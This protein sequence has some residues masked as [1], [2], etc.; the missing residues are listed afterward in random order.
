LKRFT[1]SDGGA[2]AYSDIG[3]AGARPLVLLH[4]LMAHSGF[5]REQEPLSQAF[6]LICPDLRGH[7]RSERAEGSCTV[8]RAAADVAELAETLDLQNA[9]GIG[10]SLGAT[11]LWQ[12]LAGPA[13][14]RF[15]GAVVID[16]TARVRNGDGWELGLS[17]EACAARSTAMQEDFSAFA[18]GA[19]Q[20][21]FAQP[22]S[23]RHQPTAQWAS[24]EFARND[25]AA[26]A[27]LWA[28]LESTDVRPLLARIR[29]PTLIV[30]G[31]QSSLYG[32]GTADH[33]VATLP[34]ARSHRFHHSGHAPH[35]EEPALFNDAV[36]EFV[37]A[38]PLLPNENHALRNRRMS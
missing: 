37:A 25:P 5:F 31:A 36:A 28:S 35:L 23:D 20:G 7:G 8:E 14:G 9:V 26:I 10:W 2:I 4:G 18:A 15:A 21:I 12:L 34:N 33:L 19:G 13:S 32:A 38:L 29:Q 30:H 3:P 17:P 16:M 22:I 11:I 6:R 27:A 1:A 24:A